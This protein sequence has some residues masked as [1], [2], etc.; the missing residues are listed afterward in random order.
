MTEFDSHRYENI[1]DSS[2]RSWYMTDERPFEV[3]MS[4]GTT[5][6][7]S[8]GGEAIRRTLAGNMS[9]LYPKTE[10][11]TDAERAE[12]ANANMRRFYASIGLERKDLLDTMMLAPQRQYDIPLQAVD[13]D[14][15]HNPSSVTQPYTIPERADF[16]YTRNPDTVLAARPA[17]CPIALATAET[18]SGKIMT[19]THFAW[20]GAANGFVDQMFEHFDELGIDRDTLKVYVTPGGQAESYPYA[21]DYDPREKYPAAHGLFKGVSL[22]DDGKYHYGIDTPHYVYDRLIGNGLKPEQVYADTSDT[23]RSD[24]GYSSNGRA[25]RSQGQETNIRDLIVAKMN[26]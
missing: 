15:F 9:P 17:D 26:M 8:V 3:Y 19:L 10:F 5:R 24:S 25:V 23:S 7:L 18:S 11:L 20:Q 16:L 4:V 14:Q 1:D 12:V 6:S 22:G 21:T 13:V 2:D